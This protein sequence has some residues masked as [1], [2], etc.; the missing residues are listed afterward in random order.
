MA[1]TTLSSYSLGYKEVLPQHLT[2]LA[3]V[4]DVPADELTGEFDFGV[5]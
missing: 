1:P 2:A 3:E 5:W 4:L